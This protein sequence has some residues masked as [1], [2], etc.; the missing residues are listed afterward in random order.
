MGRR[1]D[2]AKER[3][4]RL[5]EMDHSYQQRQYEVENE[6]EK[7]KA[8]A[9]EKQAKGEDV[10]AEVDQYKEYNAQQDRNFD[11]YKADREQVYS[12]YENEMQSA[13]QEEENDY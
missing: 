9:A 8:Q 6:K 10:S 12:Y 1:D 5:S 13:E 2:L 11:D 3:D 4:A 7:V